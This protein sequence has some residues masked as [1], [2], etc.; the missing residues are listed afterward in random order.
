[1]LHE[2]KKYSL[3]FTIHD[4]ALECSR[5]ILYQAGLRGFDK[6][7]SVVVVFFGVDV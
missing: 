6:V 1:V 5:Q 2:V 4:L 3:T 7:A